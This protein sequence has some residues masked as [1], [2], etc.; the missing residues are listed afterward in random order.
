LIGALL[1]AISAVVLYGSLKGATFL[2]LLKMFCR[3]LKV[4]QERESISD[5]EEQSIPGC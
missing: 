5:V 3:E 1:L 4:M 2:L